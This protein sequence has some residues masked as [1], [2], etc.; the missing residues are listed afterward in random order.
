[1]RPYGLMLLAETVAAAGDPQHALHLLDEVAA[2]ISTNKF[3]EPE[4]YRLRGEFLLAG[5]CVSSTA[6]DLIR[7]AADLAH[8]MGAHAL[9]LRAI[10]SLASAARGTERVAALEKLGQLHGQMTEGFGTSDLISAAR[11]LDL[12]A[13]QKT[14]A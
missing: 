12:A 4:L 9:E 14:D 1:M 10:L 6:L 11:L 2:T 5:N 7:R 3:C 13:G 8:E